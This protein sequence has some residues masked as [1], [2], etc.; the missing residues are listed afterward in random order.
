MGAGTAYQ[1]Y[2]ET[3]SPFQDTDFLQFILTIPVLQ[4]R[5]YKLYDAWILKK[6]PKAATWQSNQHTIGH[7][8]HI[9]TYKH[10]QI[11]IKK[12]PEILL[13][14][15]LKRLRLMKRGNIETTGKSMNPYD[16]W[17]D[18]N[19]KIQECY[20]QILAKSIH[21]L[22]T[23]PDKKQFAANAIHNGRMTYKVRAI[24]VLAALEMFLGED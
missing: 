23:L 13:F 17:F 20:E 8:P 9:V 1:Q 14:F 18:I 12:L 10:H 7:R 19:P 22:D 24:T 16:T 3:F 6:Y 11:E 4:R 21:H 2:T 15:I 5:N